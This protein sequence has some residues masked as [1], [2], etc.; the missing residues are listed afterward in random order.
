RRPTVSS[1][2]RSN[3]AKSFPPGAAA[4]SPGATQSI[5]TVAS[6][7]GI[8]L[9]RTFAA[10]RQDKITRRLAGRGT[11]QDLVGGSAPFRQR[12]RLGL[13]A[14]SQCLHVTT[15][16]KEP[17]TEFPRSKPSGPDPAA[18]GLRGSSG[19]SRGCP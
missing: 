4:E 9:A 7:T 15:Q 10:I 16:H 3:R 18:Y 11:L 8:E 19:E 17:L 13:L 1:A 6:T 2:P 5:T 14:A 12:E